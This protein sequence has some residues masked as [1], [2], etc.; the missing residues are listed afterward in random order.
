MATCV[1]AAAASAINSLKYGGLSVDTATLGVSCSA[2]DEAV[3]IV[4]TDVSTESGEPRDDK[5]S[6]EI[7]SGSK[8]I[9]R[10][11]ARHLRGSVHY[12]RFANG[13][14]ATLNVDPKRLKLQGQMP[15]HRQQL[16]P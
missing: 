6:G 14:V 10:S 4:S 16:D 5:A 15:R 1:R 7:S 8:L 12:D 9:E 13:L 2:Q 11:V 3:T